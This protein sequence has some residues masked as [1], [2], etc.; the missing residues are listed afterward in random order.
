VATFVLIHGAGGSGWVWHRVADALRAGGHEVLAPDLPCE[1]DAAAFPDYADAVVAAIGGREGVVLVAHSM[2]GFAAPL[3]PGRADVAT[4]VLLAAMVPEPGER[5]GDWWEATGQPAAQR[6]ADVRDGRVP[7]EGLGS[8]LFWH[9]LEPGLA[10]EAA[11]RRRR[12][13][14]TPFE[15][16]LPLTGWPDV[17]TRS[18]AFAD[19]R[20]LPP[21]LVRRV[22]KDRLGVGTETLP[23]GHMGMLSRPDALAARLA[24]EAG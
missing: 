6:E 1:D 24:A 19:D 15:R 5:A 4:I 10:A 16:P 3:V 12:Q 22:A 8:A 20:L 18:L 13:S 21:E 7:A 11:A 17:P 9:D 14:A 2:A 23:G